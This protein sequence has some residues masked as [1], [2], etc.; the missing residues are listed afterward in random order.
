M[1]LAFIV[2]INVLMLSSSCKDGTDLGRKNGKPLQCEDIRPLNKAAC[3]EANV[4]EGKT[5]FFMTNACVEKT[6]QLTA[7]MSENRKFISGIQG[8]KENHPAVQHPEVWGIG[9][10]Q[11]PD[12][13]TL[14]G[15]QDLKILKSLEFS[16]K[17]DTN[18]VSVAFTCGNESSREQS[19][20]Y[21]LLYSARTLSSG[22]LAIKL[23]LNGIDVQPKKGLFYEGNQL[24]FFTNATWFFDEQKQ[25]IIG[26]CLLDKPSKKEFNSLNEAKEAIKHIETAPLGGQRYY[27]VA[28]GVSG[29]IFKL[30]KTT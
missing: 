23:D 26:V 14:C 11:Q 4:I 18:I 24:D 2:L 13:A 28:Q 16:F 6:T 8:D 17:K 30:H 21:S 15:N 22:E 9:H 25:E 7:F 5:C 29:M 19:D 12:W 3:E 27:D 1:K 20:T 10:G